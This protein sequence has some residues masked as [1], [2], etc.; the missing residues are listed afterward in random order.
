MVATEVHRPVRDMRVIWIISAVVIVGMRVCVMSEELKPMGEPLVDF[1]LQGIVVTAG[2]VAQVVQTVRAAHQGAPC[3]GINE[4]RIAE[5]VVERPTLYLRHTGST[6]G[7][8]ATHDRRLVG[9]VARAVACEHV[10]P[11]VSDVSGLQRQRVRQLMLNSDVPSVQSWQSLG[12]WSVVGL[13]TICVIKEEAVWA[14][15]RE[16]P[17]GRYWRKRHQSGPT[18]EIKNRHNV[19][20][21][22]TLNVLL[23]QYR[24]VLGYG[25][26]EVRAKHSDIIATTITQPEYSFRGNLI[27]DSQTGSKSVPIV[28][29]IPI[30]PKTC[31]TSHTNYPLV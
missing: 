7:T 15:Q 29:D 14:F 1:H 2:I 4:A 8:C 31:D 6:A 19:G 27:R 18:C 9:V 5:F 21:Y 23:D 16:L 30:G 22:R 26:S 20:F 17:I 12:A 25:V 3:G 24:Q 28:A 11:A 13:N 10:R